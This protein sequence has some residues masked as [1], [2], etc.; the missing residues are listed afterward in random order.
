MSQPVCS[1][2][3]REVDRTEHLP[4]E[5]APSRRPGRSADLVLLDALAF[6]LE[7]PSADSAAEARRAAD[8]ASHREPAVAGI[9]ERLADFIEG[10]PRRAEE[11][12]TRLFDLSPACP[13]YAGYHL[14]GED[15][16]R[17]ALLAGLQG[18]L[19]RVDV[20]PGTEL[21][22]YLP[23]L[24]RLLGRLEDAD[25]RDLLVTSLILPSLEKMISGLAQAEDEP[26]ADLVRV[27]PDVVAGPV[28]EV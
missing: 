10:D 3:G 17:G 2:L 6:L 18:E 16:S 28:L 22:D 5:P 4:T 12:Y 21:P 23:T 8:R 19:R 27:L 25:E 9:L 13:L 26:Y 14:F 11:R 7:Y 24:L 15:Y 1:L 20:D